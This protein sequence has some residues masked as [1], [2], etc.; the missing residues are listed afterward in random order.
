MHLTMHDHFAE[1]TDA[2]RFPIGRKRA[3]PHMRLTTVA[4]AQRIWLETR[5]L[6]ADQRFG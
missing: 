5:A 6:T 2:P 1:W 4:D 3:L